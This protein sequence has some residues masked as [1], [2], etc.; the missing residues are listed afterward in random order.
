[1]QINLMG[2]LLLQEIPTQNTHMHTCLCA[3]KHV[4]HISGERKEGDNMR[5]GK[6][7]FSQ[8]GK[9]SWIPP[10]IWKPPE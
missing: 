9:E 2:Y 8:D 4:L 7:G 6:P 1:M 10:G 5:K 3:P